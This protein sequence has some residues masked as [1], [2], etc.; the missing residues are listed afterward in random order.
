MKALILLLFIC[1]SSDGFAQIADSLLVTV[2]RG[3]KPRDNRYIYTITIKN[4]SH[5][6]ACILHSIFINLFN[7]P[8]QRL[9]VY[10]NTDSSELYSLEYAA[11]DTLYDYEGS[12]NNFNGELILPLQEIKF[13]IL[14]LKSDK[15]KK[16]KFEY[17]RVENFCYPEFRNEIFKDATQWYKKYKRIQRLIELP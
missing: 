3:E 6:P 15:A 4:E 12:V 1:F 2:A 11:R 8:P 16:M 10:D 7:R 13:Q 14:L 5:T 17:V 9:A